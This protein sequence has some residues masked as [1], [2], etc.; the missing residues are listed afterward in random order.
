MQMYFAYVV[1]GAGLNKC[2]LRTDEDVFSYETSGC[3]NGTLIKDSPISH[4]MTSL[5]IQYIRSQVPCTV[6][7]TLSYYCCT[8]LTL[9]THYIYGTWQTPS[10]R[11][12]YA[13]LYH[14]VV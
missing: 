14:R 12:A 3:F 6:N 7:D 5:N 13:S 11:A 9:E 1:F 8:G 2:P 10:S 4:V